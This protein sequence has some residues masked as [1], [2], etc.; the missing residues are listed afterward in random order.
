[1]SGKN[2]LLRIFIKNSADHNIRLKHSIF[3]ISAT[4]LNRKDKAI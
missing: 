4:K 2:N 3:L 1:M